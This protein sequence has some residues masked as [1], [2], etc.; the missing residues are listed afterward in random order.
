MVAAFGAN[1]STP[2]AWTQ[3]EIDLV[4]AVAERTWDAVER[5]RAQEA[6]Q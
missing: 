5:T 6:L 4:T 2:R 3:L 1:N